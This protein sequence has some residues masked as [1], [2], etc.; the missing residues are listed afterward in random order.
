MGTS[1]IGINGFGRIFVY[2]YNLV[3][4]PPAIMISFV[5]AKRLSEY[6]FAFVTPVSKTILTILLF[7]STTGIDDKANSV[8]K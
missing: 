3:P 6:F 4:F 1:P 2:G 8:I 7:L 5:S